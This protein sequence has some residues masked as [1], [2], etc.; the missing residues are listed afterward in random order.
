[1]S[2]NYVCCLISYF[3]SSCAAFAAGHAVQRRIWLRMGT[4]LL[5]ALVVN[6]PTW[7]MYTLATGPD[8]PVDIR[9][10]VAHLFLNMGGLLNFG[11]YALQ[12]RYAQ[13]R[14]QAVV[15]DAMQKRKNAAGSFRVAFHVTPSVCHQISESSLG[16][17][18][19]NDG[20]LHGYFIG[21]FDE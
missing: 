1:M 10:F 19:I 21:A 4:Y 6:G 3:F 15:G 12:S 11:L 14:Q 17:T 5:V 9:A 13:P 2:L 20:V 16:D 18:G 7:Y 8:S